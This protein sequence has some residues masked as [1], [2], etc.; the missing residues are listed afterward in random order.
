MEGM[1]PAYRNFWTRKTE[2][3]WKSVR[4]VDNEGYH[5]AMAHPGLQ[6]LYGRN[7][8]DEP[9]AA[10]CGRSFAAFNESPGRL[11]S[12]RHYKKILPEMTALPES[13]RRAWLYIAI[14]PNAVIGLY[15][16]S[17]MFYQEMPLS[18]GLTIQR[19]M[20]YRYAEESREM[21]LARYLSGRIDQETGREDTQLIEW[22]YEATQSSGY[23]A[24]MLSSLENGVQTY[25]D[26]LRELLPVTRLDQE[27][28]PGTLRKV[29]DQLVK[30]DP[31]A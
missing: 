25:H 3:N 21:R 10:G 9:L 29:N 16:E 7:Y 28:E 6:D 2:V 27:P 24:A 18:T 11:W 19:G 20:V 5:V 8:Y 17:V 12:V 1:V 31:K 26:Y 22:C 4:D 14:F 15:P 30:S 23:D 13:H